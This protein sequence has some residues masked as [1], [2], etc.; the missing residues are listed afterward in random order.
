M[1]LSKCG[2]V[3]KDRDSAICYYE[4]SY[5]CVIN[6]NNYRP[7][8]E[9]ARYPGWAPIGVKVRRTGDRTSQ[10]GREV[11]P[12]FSLVVSVDSNG[13]ANAV[14]RTISHSFSVDHTLTGR[15]VLDLST[16]VAIRVHG[17][18]AP[19]ILTCST[20]TNSRE[21]KA[22]IRPTKLRIENKRPA[23]DERFLWGSR[24]EDKRR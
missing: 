5:I 4:E 22:M 24:R 15:V 23:S 1:Q 10:Q 17:L 19:E 13:V 9:K 18:P 6:V 7:P 20:L 21:K 3:N 2:M 16:A 12:S 14:Y 8:R 11:E